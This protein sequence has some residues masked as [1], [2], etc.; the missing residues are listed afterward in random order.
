MRQMHISYVKPGMV[1]GETIL[2][3]NGR[4]LLSA[5]IPLS[6]N[7]LAR[8]EENGVGTIKIDDGTNFMI[9]EQEC[10]TF[11]QKKEIMNSLKDIKFKE[12]QHVDCK[13]LNQ[14]ASMIIENVAKSNNISTDLLDTRN[15]KD[16]DYSHAIATAELSVAIAKKH[17]IY[18]DNTAKKYNSSIITVITTAALLMN[19]GKACQNEKVRKTIKVDKYDPKDVPIYG[20]LLTHDAFGVVQAPYVSTGIL[21]SKTNENGTNCPKG[22][23]AH[24]TP[25]TPINQISKILH[26]ADAYTSLIIE[27]QKD[28][29]YLSPAQAMEIIRDQCSEGIYDKSLVE[30]F[31]HHVAIFPIGMDVLLSSGE[32]AIVTD[33]NLGEEGFN[34]RPTVTT[35]DGNVYNLME[36]NNLTIIPNNKNRDFNFN[37]EA[38]EKIGLTR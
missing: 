10:L 25:K 26:I 2:G 16:Y 6:D 11:L 12:N 3:E 32:H 9:P 14:A 4:P 17:T 8:L 22:F 29:S 15:D 1:L 31:I 7:F 36:T 37:Y 13:N 24:L 35:S 27:K 5:G 33:N 28:G 30:T 18:E 19:I 21:F 38:N 23:E 20:R 34:Y